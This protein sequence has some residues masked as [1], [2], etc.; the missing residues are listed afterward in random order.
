TPGE[1]RGGCGDASERPVRHETGVLPGGNGDIEGSL[2]RGRLPELA[3]GAGEPGHADQRGGTHRGGG[4]RP[5]P[6][7]GAA[8]GGGPRAR[9]RAPGAALRAR[10]CAT[11]VAATGSWPG[12]RSPVAAAVRGRRRGGGQPSLP[13]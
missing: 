9:G 13:D 6:V 11:R 5:L 12:P 3:Q 4:R 7:V 10:S 2:C 8:G 1:A